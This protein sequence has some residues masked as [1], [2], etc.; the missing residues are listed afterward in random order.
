ML[1]SDLMQPLSRCLISPL[2]SVAEAYTP[3][4]YHEQASL[5]LDEQPVRRIVRLRR[6]LEHLAAGALQHLDPDPLR[7]I[8]TLAEEA[9]RIPADAEAEQAAKLLWRRPSRSLLVTDNAQNAI[10]LIG[11]AEIAGIFDRL[12]DVDGAVRIELP[13]R[14]GLHG[15][16]SA[17]HAPAAADVRLRA[18]LLADV[19]SISPQ[20]AVYVDE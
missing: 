12:F 11:W 2:A 9:G 7:A 10:G 13:M 14:N 19:L 16:G 4:L 6:V 8:A 1:V 15:L 20:A 5:A 17:L 3:M 18:V